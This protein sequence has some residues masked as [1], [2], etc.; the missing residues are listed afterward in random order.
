MW[1][2]SALKDTEI[3]QSEGKN[4]YSFESRV[5]VIATETQT[6]TLNDFLD[7]SA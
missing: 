3:A 4:N 1:G 7:L 2:L 6:L 5:S